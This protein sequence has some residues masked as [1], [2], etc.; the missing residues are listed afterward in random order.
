MSSGI[1]SIT[2]KINHK[3]YVG[4][5]K[6]IE[7]R[8]KAHITKNTKNVNLIHESIKKHGVD[9]FEFTILLECP[10]ICFD[11]WEKYYINKLNTIRPNG[12][13]LK[14]GGLYNVTVSGETLEK[15][16]MSHLGQLAWNKGH[17]LPSLSNEHKLKISDSLKGIKRG[18]LSEKTKELIREKR[19][20]QILPPASHETCRKISEALKGKSASPET[21]LRQSASQIA[22][23][24]M[25]P[26]QFTEETKRKI[27]EALRGKPKSE[28]AR[29]K[30]SETRKKNAESKRKLEK[31]GST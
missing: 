26:K 10:P 16:K 30:Q 6:N 31:E 22:R 5:S 4:C 12:Y 19:K 18:P 29:R 17:S 9:N 21:K 8:W 20:N 24:S 3:V 27:S 28:E 1:Y 7:S 2:N 15:M 11:Y 14:G 23:F 25:N 13:N